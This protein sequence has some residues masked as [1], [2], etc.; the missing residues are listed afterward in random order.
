VCDVRQLVSFLQSN[1]D[2]AAAWANVIGIT[3]ADIPAYVDDLTSVILRS[4]TRV[5]NHGFANG[6]ATNLQSLLQAGTA[7]LVDKFGVPRVRCYCGNPLTPPQEV[8]PTYQGPSWPGFDPGRVTVIEASPTPIINIVLINIVDGTTFQRPVGTQGGSDVKVT[9]IPNRTPNTRNGTTTSKPSSSTSTTSGASTTQA[10]AIKIIHD[11]LAKCIADLKTQGSTSVTGS[12]DDL[13]Y[14]AT[15]LGGSAFNVVV[16]T[17]DGSD[18]GSWRV[19]TK[20]GA[21]TPTDQTAS[22]VGGFCPGLA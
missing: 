7:V 16:T 9:I 22:E 13:K 3:P 19:D 5:T 8:Q 18:Q 21:V 6:A 10:A 20:T 1:A 12:A 17:A 11:G 2:K 4:D 14:S 15:P